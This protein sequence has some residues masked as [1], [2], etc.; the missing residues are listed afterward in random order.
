M[1]PANMITSISPGGVVTPVLIQEVV[2]Q[3]LA[4]EKER[5]R[6]TLEWLGSLAN[7]ALTNPS[8]EPVVSALHRADD[9]SPVR[10]VFEAARS[11][12]QQPFTIED[13][14]QRVEVMFPDAALSSGIISRRLYDLRIRQPAIVSLATADKAK[15]VDTF[16]MTRKTYKYIGPSLAESPPG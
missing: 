4:Q 16:P 14:C 9:L 1:V 2:N 11:F 3:L 8:I 13:L 10:M 7:A 15:P 5:H 6:K 12:G